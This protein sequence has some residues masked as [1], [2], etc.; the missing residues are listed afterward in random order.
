MVTVLDDESVDTWLAEHPEW[1][2]VGPAAAGGVIRRSVTCESFP[3]AIE[4]VQRIAAV[5]EE[6]DH[7]PN[8]DIRWRTLHFTLSTHSAGGLTDKDLA[9]AAVIDDLA[10]RQD[11]T[12]G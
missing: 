11:Q 10:L 6:R 7:H 9:M 3:A 2:R 12:H 5:A 4:L 8:I 1:E